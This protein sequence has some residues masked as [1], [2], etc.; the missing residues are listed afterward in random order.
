MVSPVSRRLLIGGLLAAAAATPNLA[1]AAATNPPWAAQAQTFV[2]RL[3]EDLARISRTTAAGSTARNQ[4][5]AA[6][7][8]RALALDR[9]GAFLLGANR[10]K[11][12]AQQL[13]EYQQL[14]ANYIVKQFASQIDQLAQQQFSYGSVT[15]R[16]NNEVLVQSSFERTSNKTTIP[17]S[18]RIV[19]LENGQ[20]R[21]LDTYV[22]G[23]SPWVERR[24][25]FS[26]IIAK[27]GIGGLLVWLRRN[28]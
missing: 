11:G 24:E 23:I 19:R 20:L 18:W 14:A 17:V 8:T 1:A 9:I 28:T 21:L 16:S 27:E 26:S 22:N 25:L 15:A 12:T 13:T 10:S 7:V 4:Q 2:S 3:I 5:L 6:V